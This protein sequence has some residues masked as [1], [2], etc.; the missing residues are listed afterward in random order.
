MK[1]QR[2]GQ[3]FPKSDIGERSLRTGRQTG[4]L[5]NMDQQA[6][7][8]QGQTPCQLSTISCRE[9]QNGS[10]ANSSFGKQAKITV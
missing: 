2:P 1:G 10:M 5:E 6:R 9:G 4:L 8:G 7:P 3:D